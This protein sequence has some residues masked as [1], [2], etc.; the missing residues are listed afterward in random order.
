[1]KIVYFSYIWDI[2]GDSIGPTIKALQLFD[3]LEKRGHEIKMYWRRDEFSRAAGPKSGQK[4]VSV[5]DTLKKHFKR[6]LHEPS[7]LLKNIPS[8]RQEINILNEEKPDLI[9]SRL[10]SY[11][12]SPAYI[13]RK[14]SLPFLIEIDCPS[15][16]EKEVFQSYYRSTGRLVRY[17]EKSFI[18][19]GEEGFT[20]SNQ[21]KDYFVQ[22]GFAEDKITVIPNGADPI[23]FSPDIDATEV[24]RQYHLDGSLV[25]GFVGSFIYW[26]G[27][28]NLVS[29][30]KRSLQ[31][32]D[33]VKF[34]MVGN[35]GPLELYLR[36][37]IEENKLQD[38][39]ILTG[40]VL[41]E[42]VPCYIA[43]MDVVLAPYPALDF[44]Y[45]SPLKIYEYMS[46]GKALISTNVGQIAEV[47]EDGV[48]GYLT[49]PNDIDMITDYV[50]QLVRDNAGRIAMGNKAR[51][52]I[53]N[54]HTWD[55]RGEQLDKLCRKY[56]D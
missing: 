22:R 44:F 34:L 20:V 16:Y 4:K 23:K 5:R 7:Q 49:P 21:L 11:I 54:H 39:V 45:Y 28:E 14:V 15:A 6:Y 8:I 47:I 53:L 48:T 12:F 37:F 17:L 46:C 41:H 3:A 50:S 26:H 25:V 56:Y 55:K 51:E 32:N 38:R 19:A 30:I 13:S 9:I 40:Y 31:Q 27:I 36:K 10:D 1:M 2:W 33:Q 24:K 52:A 42:D 35:G 29:V 43:A 18:N